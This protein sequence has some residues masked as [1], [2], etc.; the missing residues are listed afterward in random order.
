MKIRRIKSTGIIAMWSV[1]INL[2][3]LYIRVYYIL[4]HKQDRVSH[5]GTRLESQCS[6]VE[7]RRISVSSRPAWFT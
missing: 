4:P 1:D 7:G 3:F 6:G 5:D 2:Y